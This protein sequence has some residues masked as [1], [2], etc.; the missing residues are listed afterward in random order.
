MGAG[1]VLGQSVLMF[2]GRQKAFLLKKLAAF[3]VFGFFFRS[4]SP[5]L[6][7]RAERGALT[8]EMFHCSIHSRQHA[9][10]GGDGTPLARQPRSSV[11]VLQTSVSYIAFASHP[12]GNPGANPKSISHRCH[13]IL[14]AFVWEWTQETINLPLGCL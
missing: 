6:L 13:P 3:V 1:N 2:K 8:C 14:V 4:A 7:P 12:G 9:G 10:F 11:A 5:M